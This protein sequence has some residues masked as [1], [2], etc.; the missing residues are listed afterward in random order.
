MRGG[1][2]GGHRRHREGIFLWE[3]SC[4]Q[5]WEARGQKFLMG[6][7]LQAAMGGVRGGASY[8]LQASTA[9]RGAP[10]VQLPASPSPGATMTGGESKCSSGQG[11]ENLQAKCQMSL[12]T[13][14]TSSIHDM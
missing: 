10:V 9:Q 12:P 7:E 2:A 4:K 5:P 3:R 1:A 8:G 13:N 11:D 6:A 14:E